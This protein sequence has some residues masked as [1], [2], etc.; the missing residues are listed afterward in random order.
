MKKVSSISF[1]LIFLLSL[2]S[3]SEDV[4]YNRAPLIDQ[5]S[6]TPIEGGYMIRV[7]AHD[8]DGDQVSYSFSTN[9]E[10]ITISQQEEEATITGSFQP[11]TNIKV[12]GSDQH[13]GESSSSFLLNRTNTSPLVVALTSEVRPV[14]VGQVFTI[15][16]LA[17]DAERDALQYVFRSNESGI[18]I[19]PSTINS[20]VPQAEVTV[21]ATISDSVEF[22][23]EVTDV[24]GGKGTMNMYLPV[25]GT[26][27]VVDEID[28][29][30]PYA[31]T[32]DASNN[33][34]IG[35]RYNRVFVFDLETYSPSPSFVL[36]NI[37]SAVNAG[38]RSLYIDT[39]TSSHLLYYGVQ[40]KTETYLATQE[41]AS[42]SV[43]LPNAFA[44]YITK[45]TNDRVL[46]ANENDQS[47]E[48]YNLSGQ[49][50]FV[51]NGPQNMNESFSHIRQIFPD[52]VHQHLYVADRE[53]NK[54]RV[55]DFNGNQIR[56]IGTNLD[57]PHG[58]AYDAEYDVVYV[59]DTGGNRVLTYR[60]DGSFMAEVELP[61]GFVGEPRYILIDKNHK[62]YIP[63]FRKNKVLVFE[64]R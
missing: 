2:S 54:I 9:S 41:G 11:W 5:V 53:N 10:N 50:Q 64:W 23:V 58:V 47:I 43:W 21:N 15:K 34:L 25:F 48:C 29:I 14:A 3:C 7:Q 13:G 55:L 51:W 60:S 6:K 37:G 57:I 16:A 1:F 19:S 24:H 20:G 59:S 49:R 8:L 36:S 28:V 39:T 22:T 4:G 42:E 32:F 45:F 12:I 56:T 27:E 26:P 40:T 46:I 63:F 38:V 52:F 30:T 33:I 35:N 44:H 61:D 62:V 31:M 18:H 17:S